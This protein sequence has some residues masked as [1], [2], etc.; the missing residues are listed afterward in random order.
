AKAHGR[1]LRLEREAAGVA[2]VFFGD[3]SRNPP[4]V[5]AL[6]AAE[7]LRF[8]VLAPLLALALVALL[9]HI[10]WSKGQLAIA[11]LLWAPTL[12]LTVLGVASFARAGGLDRGAVVG[13]VLWWALVAA[14][15][16]FVVVSANGR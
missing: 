8:W 5:E 9:H 12:A 15:A 13:S 2:E 1:E 4:V 7:R 11:G 10:G 16:A 14:A 6:W 3:L